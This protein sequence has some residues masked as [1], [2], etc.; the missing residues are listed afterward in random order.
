MLGEF[1]RKIRQSMPQT[2]AG[3]SISAGNSIG[4]IERLLKYLFKKVTAA[5]KAHI[6][7]KHNL[8]INNSTNV[9]LRN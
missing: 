1:N 2:P 3:A 7:I 4:E 5:E 9:F 6:C 8:K